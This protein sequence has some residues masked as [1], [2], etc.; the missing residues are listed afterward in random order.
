MLELK[1]CNAGATT[2]CTQSLV[3]VPLLKAANGLMNFNISGLAGNTDYTFFVTVKN[4]N[5]TSIPALSGEFKTLAS[6]RLASPAVSN[7]TTT[8]AKV[9]VSVSGV[10]ANTNTQIEVKICSAAATVPCPQ[11]LVYIPV[12]NAV[13]ELMNF[14]IS[15][16]SG[17]TN[18]TVFVL[19]KNV[20]QTPVPAAKS[21]FQTL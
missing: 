6:V 2:P 4:V 9:S 20:N 19:P 14:D 7:K 15:G 10:V 16:L 11:S 13:N 12:Q 3:N 17:R 8:G 18:Y 1:V 21:S 5:Q